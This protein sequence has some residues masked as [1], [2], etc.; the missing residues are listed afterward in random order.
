MEPDLSKVVGFWEKKLLPNSLG[1]GNL[2]ALQLSCKQVPD[3][4]CLRCPDP[5]LL[6]MLIPNGSEPT[7]LIEVAAWASPTPSLVIIPKS[8]PENYPPPLPLPYKV[9]SPRSISYHKLNQKK[10]SENERKWK[11]EAELRMKKTKKQKKKL[12]FFQEINN[13]GGTGIEREGGEKMWEDRDKARTRSST[14]DYVRISDMLAQIY[15]LLFP[16]KEI[17]FNVFF[18][19]LR[20]EAL[21]I[22][23]ILFLR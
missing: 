15:L 23:L 4:C 19:F 6:E 14:K 11:R 7:A 1:L 17:F 2:P 8:I 20:T 10:Q 5:T 9:K 16:N 3:L 12:I 13:N 21:L 22:S 18:F